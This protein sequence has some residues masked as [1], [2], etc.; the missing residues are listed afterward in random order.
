LVADNDDGESPVTYSYSLCFGTIVPSL[1]WKVAAR[2]R[3]GWG[4]KI[5]DA[6]TRKLASTIEEED[7]EEEEEE[8][9]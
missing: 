7:G 1:D 2:S 5:R 9:E 3:E 4:Q 6:M 8:E